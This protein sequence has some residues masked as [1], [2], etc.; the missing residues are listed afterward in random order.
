[1]H[2]YRNINAINYKYIKTCVLESKRKA[3]F[4]QNNLIP[5]T[6]GEEKKNKNKCQCLEMGF[7]MRVGK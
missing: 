4:M 6:G 5:V 3:V 2:L 7:C 1:M